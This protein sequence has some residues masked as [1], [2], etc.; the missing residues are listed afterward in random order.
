[1]EGGERL[2]RVLAL[3][4]V[5][6]T[7]TQ[8]DKILQLNVAGFTNTEVADLLQTTTGVVNQVLYQS[9]KGTKQRKKPGTN[10]R[11]RRN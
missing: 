2:E 10:K 6:Q 5:Q 9:R 1:M 8:R 11:K 7:K 3:L 4:L